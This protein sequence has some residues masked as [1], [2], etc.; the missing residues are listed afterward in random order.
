MKSFFIT[1][2]ILLPLIGNTQEKQVINVYV[3]HLKPPFIIDLKKESGLYF[4]FSS[5]LNSKIDNY[6]F[7][8][9]F[10]PRKRLTQMLAHDLVDGMILGVNPVWFADKNEEKHLWSN[11]IITDQDDFI[12][13]ATNPFDYQ[14]VNS[15]TSRKL[16]GVRGFYYKGINELVSENKIQRTD[17]INEKALLNMLLAK[18]IDVAIVSQ[19]TFHYITKNKD[20]RD[21]FYISLAPHDTFFRRVLF[22]KNQRAIFE[23]IKPTIN[24]M[25]SSK[26]WQKTLTQYQ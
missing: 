9:V 1:L 24:T 3:Y 5:Y 8:T 18:H 2:C 26:L 12:S 23:Q 4:D 14:G 6:H 20:L 11:K 16:G 17:T 19:S 15:L 10:I 25:F 22:P 21:K 13:L 7:K